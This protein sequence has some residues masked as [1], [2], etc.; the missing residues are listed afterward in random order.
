MAVKVRCPTCEKVLNAP[1]A[2]RGKAVKCP[3]CET[4]IKIPA[5]DT[6]AESAGGGG[7]KTTVRRSAGRTAVK[8]P[9]G[10]SSEFLAGLDLDK[11]VDSS[12]AM[13]PKCGTSIPEGATECPKCGVDP[14]TGQLSSAA[15]KRKNMK[16][17]DP[18]LF[19]G[20]AWKDS[21]AF[22][23]ENYTVALRT[24]MY[25]TLLLGFSGGCFAL[26]NWLSGQPPKYF[27]GA[28]IAAA[29]LAMPGWVW[30]LTIETIRTTAAKKSNIRSIHFDVFR[31]I[32]LGIKS[33]LW[34]IVFCTWLPFVG[35]MTPVAMVHM[36]MPV[37][38]KG[39][40]MPAIL[41]IFFRNFLPA[42]YCALVSFVTSL[43]PSMVMGLLFGILAACFGAAN[44]SSMSAGGQVSLGTAAKWGLYGGLVV[45]AVVYFVVLGFFILFNVRVL[46]LL[47]YYFQNS[48]DLTTFI[49]EKVYVRKEVKVD[50]WG[51][52]IKS[53]GQKV[54]EV[55]IVVGVLVVIG[56][57]GFF[58]YRQ[59]KGS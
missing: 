51:N 11:I 34:S 46:G 39:W 32:A 1:D 44:L 30:W 20:A 25:F 42:M 15:R 6:S 10:D 35:F 26:A 27:L 28:F 3:E 58:V 22:M 57:V 40:L 14:L 19:Y 8:K 12:E 54:K 23:L 16:G 48:L 47:A 52:P 21:W 2:A 55:A 18:A 13:C 29:F 45:S 50:K 33:I 41:P 17:P 43:V 4:K 31:N 37:T 5:G 24:G 7:A 53:S 9:A 59:L 49:T 36:A 38:K 56:V